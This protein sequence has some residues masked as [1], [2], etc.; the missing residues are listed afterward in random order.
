MQFSRARFL[1]L[2]STMYQ[3]ASGMLVRANISSLAL[4]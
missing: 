4:V 3:G 2:P 1:S